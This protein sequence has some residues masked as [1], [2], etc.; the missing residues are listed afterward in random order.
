VKKKDI[1]IGRNE[2]QRWFEDMAP[3]DDFW[4]NFR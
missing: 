4:A 1:S 3:D 2:T